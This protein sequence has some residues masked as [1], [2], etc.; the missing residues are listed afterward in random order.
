[1]W[2]KSFPLWVALLGLHQACAYPRRATP[3]TPLDHVAVRA[4]DA[5]DGMFR[6]EIVAAEVPN[7]QRSGLP[8]DDEEGRPDPFVKVFIDGKPIWETPKV[9]DSLRPE[10]R[11]SPP[12]N[13]AIERARSRIRLELWDKDGIGNDPIGMYE[14][15]ALANAQLDADTTVPLEGSATLTFRVRAPSPHAGV[16]IAS[17]EVRKDALLVLKVLADSPASRA[18]LRAGDRIVALAGRSV[19]ELGQHA[20]ESGL[21]LAAQNRTELTV[22]RGEHLRTVTLDQGYIWLSM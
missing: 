8:W 1:M 10:F 5:P 11:S 4:P 13:L 7:V 9:D 20:A 18:E 21:A 19:L 12:R 3:L 6:L 14:G 17:Y 16:G 15:R 2:G 22:K